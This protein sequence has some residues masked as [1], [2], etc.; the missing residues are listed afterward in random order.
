MARL[1][2]SR[3]DFENG[4]FSCDL[5]ED[6][7]FLILKV[8]TKMENHTYVEDTEKQTE[9]FCP[10]K[11]TSKDGKQVPQ[12]LPGVL[13]LRKNDISMTSDSGPCPSPTEHEY[14]PRY[15]N[16]P[17]WLS[18][19]KEN[20]PPIESVTPPS[21]R[22]L[23]L[24]EQ[25][26]KVEHEATSWEANVARNLDSLPR[27][28]S[29]YPK[30]KTSTL[31]DLETD[32]D[33]NMVDMT[34]F[35]ERPPNEKR[36]PRP[37]QSNSNQEQCPTPQNSPTHTPKSSLSTTPPAKPHRNE[38]WGILPD[39]RRVPHGWPACLRRQPPRVA[40]R[41]NNIYVIDDEEYKELRERHPKVQYKLRVCDNPAAQNMPHKEDFDDNNYESIDETTI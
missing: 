4:F 34:D 41:N 38:I 21:L 10:W 26:N 20:M 29:P 24:E 37:K 33:D 19:D 11:K 36:S 5:P 39:K 6:A 13:T 16:K 17:E 15:F 40:F 22:N 8:K 35:F 1:L 2:N 27:S 28:S 25:N 31:E 30:K 18:S 7:V 9:K 32:T 14:K 3:C 12:K 23:S